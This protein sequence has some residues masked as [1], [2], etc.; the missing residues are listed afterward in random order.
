MLHLLTVLGLTSSWVDLHLACCRCAVGVEYIVLCPVVFCILF[1]SFSCFYHLHLM[2]FGNPMYS[3]ALFFIRT[4]GLSGPRSSLMVSFCLISADLSEGT[5]KYI[6][7][8]PHSL[9]TCKYPYP[10]EYPY[11]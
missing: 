9:S 3:Y 6:C 11:L 5:R 7:E 1:F 4:M 2:Y 10:H 8:Y